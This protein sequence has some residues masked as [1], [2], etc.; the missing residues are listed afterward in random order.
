MPRQCLQIECALEVV[1]SELFGKSSFKNGCHFEKCNRVT[2]FAGLPAITLDA[3]RA[4]GATASA[5]Q[6]PGT[7]ARGVNTPPWT[8]G[9]VCG[10]G[11]EVH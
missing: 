10:G 8:G 2:D 9:G 6:N 4:T 1:C 11:Q 5:P 7:A 3:R